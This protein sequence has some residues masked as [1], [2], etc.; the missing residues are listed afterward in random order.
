MDFFLNKV[1]DDINLKNKNLS[2]TSF[3]LPN[4]RSAKFFKQIVLKKIKTPSF[5]PLICSIDF[6]IV[7]MSGLSE[8]RHSKQILFLYE[9][10]LSVK[11]NN[12]QESFE[13]FMSWATVFLNDISE[14]DQNLADTVK[15][16]EELDEINKISN[17][18][19]E[20]SNTKENLSFWK[21]LPK[22]YELFKDRVIKKRIGDQRFML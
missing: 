17:W 16:L 2:S 8:A 20:A 4:K 9:C 1:V 5:V 13:E 11:K 21:F 7:E 10:Y 3:I 14:L 12:K 15:T 19:K 22:L 6:F 18:G